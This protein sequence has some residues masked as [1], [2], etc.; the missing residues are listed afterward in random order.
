MCGTLDYLPP[1][2]VQ[3]KEYTEKV[4]LWCVGILTY[5]FLVGRPPFETEDA[6]QT[7]KKIVTVDYKFPDYITDIAQDFISKVS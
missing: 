7:Y 2:M 1:E 3:H 4:D 5:E 6:N